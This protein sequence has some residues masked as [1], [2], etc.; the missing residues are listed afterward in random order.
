MDCFITVTD[1]NDITVII[2]IS[3]VPLI[4]I[5]A[6]SVVFVI[7]I[8]IIVAI[9]SIIILDFAVDADLV[10][11]FLLTAINLEVSIVRPFDNPVYF[12][13]FI[14]HT[15]SPIFSVTTLKSSCRSPTSF[16]TARNYLEN[17]CIA[18]RR[19]MPHSP[20]SKSL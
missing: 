16:E 10:L 7:N 20:P 14:I 18:H 9:V 17:Q 4:I 12:L 6:V 5:I 13:L 8:T 11:M 1:I 3:I 15:K 2:A 19:P